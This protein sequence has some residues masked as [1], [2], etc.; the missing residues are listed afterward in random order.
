VTKRSVLFICTGNSARSQMAEAFVR[1][2]GGDRFDAFSAGL[3]PR[4]IHPFT[5]QVMAER[6]IDISE[7]RSKN[8]K[9][10]LGKRTFHHVV[11][12]CALAEQNCPFLWPGALE[13]LSWPFRD[14][15][16]TAGDD[17]E[18]LAAFRAVRDQIEMRIT[19]WLQ[20]SHAT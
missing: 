13:I 4:E 7:Q 18:R 6:G 15:A 16:N 8:L 12:V 1:Y 17:Q 11:T 9:Q 10:F 5:T 20:R 14:P 19:T 2:H 3:A